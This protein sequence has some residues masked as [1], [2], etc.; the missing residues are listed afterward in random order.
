MDTV[1]GSSMKLPSSSL[2]HIRPHL[3]HLKSY[4]MTVLIFIADGFIIGKKE[5]TFHFFLG[6]ETC[7][8][9]D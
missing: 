1:M 2:L 7:P 3:R 4:P 6:Y 8:P 9:I 5:G